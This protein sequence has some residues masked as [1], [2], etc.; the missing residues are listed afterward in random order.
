M[1]FSFY[2]FLCHC[3]DV[4]DYIKRWFVFAASSTFLVV[5]NRLENLLKPG[6]N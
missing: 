3:L 1:F 6:N 2:F 5:I 4:D